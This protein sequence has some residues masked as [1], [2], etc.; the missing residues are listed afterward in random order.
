[1]ILFRPYIKGIA[2]TWV[3]GSTIVPVTDGWD[4]VGVYTGITTHQRVTLKH[5]FYVPST[6]RYTLD[7]VICDYWYKNDPAAPF[8]TLPIDSALIIKPGTVEQYLS[9]DSLNFPDW[10]Y[11]DLPPCPT[12]WLPQP[13]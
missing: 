7:W 3:P 8:G 10:Y 13:W 4:V 1:M 5:E 11:L 12:S 6:N 9:L 2:V